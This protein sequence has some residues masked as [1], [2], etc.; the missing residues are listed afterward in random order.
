MMPEFL[1]RLVAKRLL[2]EPPCTGTYS[3]CKLWGR[4]ETW[5]GL[6]RAGLEQH[7]GFRCI[8]DFCSPECGA[9]L[10]HVGPLVSAATRGDLQ[11]RLEWLRFVGAV[12][13][14]GRKDLYWGEIKSWNMSNTNRLREEERP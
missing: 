2:G 4:E 9:E 14:E 11:R 7:L 6:A 1:A 13:Q 12:D 8:K 3:D 10:S 5:V